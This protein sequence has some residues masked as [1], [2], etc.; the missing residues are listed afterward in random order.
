MKRV[1]MNK[2]KSSLVII[3]IIMILVAVLIIFLLFTQNKGPVSGESGIVGK[4]TYGPIAPVCRENEPCSKAYTGKVIIK[5][6]DKS[7]EITSFS[8]DSNGEFKISI[9][10]GTYYLETA[11]RFISPCGQIV[12]VEQ[13]QFTNITL[14]CDTG[15]R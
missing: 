6:E 2:R 14:D 5:T 7:R 1:S 15:I 11:Q 12:R 13:S 10:P 9:N 4:I 3:A 8:T